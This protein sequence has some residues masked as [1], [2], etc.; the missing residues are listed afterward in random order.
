M[1]LSGPE[2]HRFCHL[3]S[4]LSPTLGKSVVLFCIKG[5]RGKSEDHSLKGLFAGVWLCN[6]IPISKA[7]LASMRREGK[8][9]SPHPRL[10]V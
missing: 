8:Y 1:G 3:R 7:L 9:L 10:E 6:F 2:C 5:T 4:M